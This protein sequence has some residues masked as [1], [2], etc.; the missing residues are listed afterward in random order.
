M[1]NPVPPLEL[2]APEHQPRFAA[3]KVSTLVN[4]VKNNYEALLDEYVE[5]TQKSDPD[6]LF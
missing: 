6:T 4:S 5:I 1:C 2:F 3:R